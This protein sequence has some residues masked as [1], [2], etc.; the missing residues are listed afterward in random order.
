MVSATVAAGYDW[1]LVPPPKGC[2]RASDVTG[3]FEVTVTGRTRP[4][5]LKERRRTST[6]STYELTGSRSIETGAPA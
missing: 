1:P 2:R 6:N 4:D 5:E 3:V